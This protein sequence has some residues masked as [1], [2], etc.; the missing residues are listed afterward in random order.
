MPKVTLYDALWFVFL[1]VSAFAVKYGKRIFQNVIKN[2]AHSGLLTKAE[3]EIYTKV[4][5]KLVEILIGMHCDRAYIFSFHNGTDLAGKISRKKV[6]CIFEQVSQGTSREIDKLR[7][8]DVTS[9]WDWVQCFQAKPS[10]LPQGVKVMKN[11]PRCEKCLLNKRV[12]HFN[13]DDLPAGYMK[14]MLVEQGI[15]SM[16]QTLILDQTGGIMG[17]LGVDYCDTIDTF[18]FPQCDLCHEADVI[19]L[20]L[21]ELSRAKTTLWQYIRTLLEK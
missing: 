15:T 1:G 3:H 13:I 5:N 20:H 21:N 19:A 17:I 6:S 9:I 2:S 11:N 4:N 14:A 16:L 18:G 10:E 12:L 8:M 7:D